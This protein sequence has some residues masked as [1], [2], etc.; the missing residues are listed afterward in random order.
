[1]EFKDIVA[2]FSIVK[3]GVNNFIDYKREENEEIR[4]EIISLN[5]KVEDLMRR[6]AA[7]KKDIKRAYTAGKILNKITGGE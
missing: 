3:D 6:E 7:N 1:M 4:Q 2:E 5:A